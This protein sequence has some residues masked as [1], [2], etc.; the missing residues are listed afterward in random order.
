MLDGLVALSGPHGATTPP[1]GVLGNG[2][3]GR[4][5][6]GHETASDAAPT[7]AGQ[8]D[9]AGAT[10]D[11][12]GTEVPPSSPSKAHTIAVPLALCMDAGLQAEAADNTTTS[13]V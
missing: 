6:L 3:D 8:A 7:T 1:S 9:H 11:Q 2:K 12:E 10:G 5:S 4:P 13:V